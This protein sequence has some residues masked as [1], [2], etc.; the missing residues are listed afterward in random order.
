MQSNYKKIIKE[1]EEEIKEVENEIFI[2][3]IDGSLVYLIPK[4]YK[5]YKQNKD[6][7]VKDLIIEGKRINEYLIE[8]FKSNCDKDTAK[9]LINK[10]MK[11][12]DKYNLEEIIDKIIELLNR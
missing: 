11:F 5:L 2:E 12:C 7:I 4:D 8:Y 3:I 10:S 9:E 1:L 6:I